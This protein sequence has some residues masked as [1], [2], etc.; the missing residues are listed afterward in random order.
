VEILKTVDLTIG[1]GEPL[2]KDINVSLPERCLL[3]VLGPNGSG[4]TT[5]LKTVLGLLKPLSGKIYFKG[6]D[7]TSKPDVVSK[8]FGYVPQIFTPTYFPYPVTVREFVETAYMLYRSG[9]PRIRASKSVEDK[10]RSVLELVGLDKSLWDKNIWKL[11]G[12]Q[13]QRALIARAL[14]YEPEILVLDEPLAP[15]DPSGRASIAEL[16]GNL[17]KQVTVI[18]SSHDPT[19]LLRYTSHVLLL[20]NGFYFFGSPDEVLRSEV[21]KVVYGDLAYA[22]DKHIHIYDH[23]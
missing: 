15:V 7:I 18:V 22:M 1:Y 19:I 13:R 12:G 6:V 17:T 2:V 9:W 5:F 11:S 4:K 23:H 8:V 10:I 14:V 3:Q 16:I 21:L 20:G